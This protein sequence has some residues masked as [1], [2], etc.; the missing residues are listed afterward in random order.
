MCSVCRSWVLYE[1]NSFLGNQYVLSEGDYANLTSMGC[2]HN[3]ILRSV[4]PVSIVSPAVSSLHLFVL[5]SKRL[6]QTDNC[7]KKPF[8]VFLISESASVS[9]P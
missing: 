4:K 2:S 1:E 8:D 5:M 7:S 9:Q 6:L 3:C